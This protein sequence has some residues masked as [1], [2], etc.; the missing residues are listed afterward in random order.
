MSNHTAEVVS[1]YRNN[2]NTSQ[3]APY[4][5]ND[6][7]AQG[8]QRAERPSYV[9]VARSAPRRTFPKRD[10]AIVLNAVGS[11]K[12]ADYVYAVADITGPKNITHVSRISNDRICVFLSSIQAV[13]KLIEG[14][15]FLKI[16]TDEVGI[17]RLI[18]PAK[19]IILSNVYPTIPD[20]AIEDALRAI[21]LKLVSPITD[22]RAGIPKDGF[23]HILSFRR[24]VYVAPPTE[25]VLQTQSSVLITYEGTQFRIYL[26]EDEIRCYQCRQMGHI[27]KNC[28][29]APN[30]VPEEQ[31]ISN[32]TVADRTVRDTIPP[33]ETN[34][35]TTK[36]NHSRKA[37]TSPSLSSVP[38]DNLSCSEDPDKDD[39]LSLRMKRPL[40]SQT[41]TE[42]SA[43]DE[44]LP[45]PLTRSSG[46]IS[47]HVSRKEA[48]SRNKKARK[49]SVSTS[50]VPAASMESIREIFGREVFPI[51]FESFRSFLENSFGNRNPLAE[52]ERFTADVG[53]ILKIMHDIYKH[54][55]DRS[56]KSRFTRISRRINEQLKAEGKDTI[57]RMTTSPQ[58]SQSS[59]LSQENLD[60]ALM[61]LSPT[62]S[63]ISY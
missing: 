58:Q 55:P 53:I 32:A 62:D 23:L 10:L 5:Q 24:Q 43:N 18:T 4:S 33:A 61:D 11:L 17:R 8:S 54:L 26:T 7:S 3:I 30:T 16:G 13:D 63:Q 48:S 9:N 21:G 35:P 22:L 25:Q 52:A 12:L 6:N 34:Q 50:P 47:K 46:A 59:Q 29:I 20:E 60:Q 27:A 41:S 28:P 39:E 15:D 14:R 42:T 2:R 1:D 49:S 51:P 57:H 31:S 40:E 36:Q 56:L 44:I 37:E 45:Q 19:R 38:V